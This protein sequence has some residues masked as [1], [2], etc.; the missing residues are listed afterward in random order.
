M[1]DC[2]VTTR[3]SHPRKLVNKTFTTL[4]S[5]VIRTQGQVSGVSVVRD[6]KFKFIFMMELSGQS[7]PKQEAISVILF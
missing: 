2:L 3:V 7:K 1:P 5:Y 4:T 6:S